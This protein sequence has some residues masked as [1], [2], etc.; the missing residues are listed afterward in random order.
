VVSSP[1]LG[2]SPLMPL[3]ARAAGSTVWG[4]AVLWMGL[5]LRRSTQFIADPPARAVTVGTH[6]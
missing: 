2:L 5:T 6:G 4:I 3:W 1:I